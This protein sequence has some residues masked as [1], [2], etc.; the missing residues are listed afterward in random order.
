MSSSQWV[1]HILLKAKIIALSD[2]FEAIKA[3]R[4][5]RD[6]YSFAQAVEMMTEMSLDQEIVSELCKALPEL[7]KELSDRGVSG[8]TWVKLESDAEVL[9]K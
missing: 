2:V 8:D 9:V 3:E 6:A 4:P 7:E 5:Y 1:E